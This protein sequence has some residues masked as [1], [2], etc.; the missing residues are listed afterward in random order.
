MLLALVEMILG[1][2][3]SDLRF[4]YAFGVIFV[5]YVFLKMLTIF[6]DIIRDLVGGL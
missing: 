4:L 6:L 2:L 1:E 5:L 3:P